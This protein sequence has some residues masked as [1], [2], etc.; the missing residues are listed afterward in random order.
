MIGEHARFAVG[1]TDLLFTLAAEVDGR[2]E[3]E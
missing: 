2:F 1:V 3:I